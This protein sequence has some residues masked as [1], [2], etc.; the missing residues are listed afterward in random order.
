MNGSRK[1]LCIYSYIKY[2]IH[3]IIYNGIL[4][5]LKKEGNPAVC[6]DMGES[7]GPTATWNKPKTNT[8]WYNLYV[9]SKQEKIKLTET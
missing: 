2:I 9:Q 6:D 1:C 3:I 7:A 4:L 8:A 5:S